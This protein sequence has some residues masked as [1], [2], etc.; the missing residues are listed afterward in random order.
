MARRF[1]CP[2]GGW[3]ELPDEWLGRH[4]AKR[5][6]AAEKAAQLPP[7][8]R[9]FAISMALLENWGDLRGLSGNPDAWDFERVQW[10]TLEWVSDIVTVD[11]VKALTVPKKSLLPR[12]A[13]HPAAAETTTAQP[14]S[15]ES[16]PPE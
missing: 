12:T 16:A 8:L 7:T 4:A 3:I 14:G 13:G 5:D 11:L 6:R 1:E 2:H 10:A 9:R 15:S